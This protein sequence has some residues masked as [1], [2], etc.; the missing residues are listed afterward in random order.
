MSASSSCPSLHFYAT[1]IY[2]SPYRFEE[3]I[4]VASSLPN[5]SHLP[6]SMRSLPLLPLRSCSLTRLRIYIVGILFV[7]IS[8]IV[9]PLALRGVHFHKLFKAIFHCQSHSSSVPSSFESVTF[10]VWFPLQ[11]E[12]GEGESVSF[13]SLITWE[14][15]MC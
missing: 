10:G 3:Y 2:L 12:H 11:P 1:F 5:L 9:S 7:F 13:Q 6:G 8:P 15:S 14:P 4:V